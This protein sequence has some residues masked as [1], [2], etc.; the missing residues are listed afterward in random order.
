MA[1]A[2]ETGK[3]KLRQRNCITATVL[4]VR[5]VL[6]FGCPPVFSIKRESRRTRQSGEQ[7]R[8]EGTSNP[9]GAK[10]NQVLVLESRW[11]IGRATTKARE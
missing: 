2:E 1:V 8:E 3:L 10:V 11:S 7:A 6:A 5:E 4:E 9:T